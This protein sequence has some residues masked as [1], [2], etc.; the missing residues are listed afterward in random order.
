M[1]GEKPMTCDDA[2]RHLAVFLDGEL[3]GA[4]HDALEHHLEICRSCFSR[5]EFERRLK[6]EVG[7]LRRDDVPASF[8]DRIRHLL[9]SFVPTTARPSDNS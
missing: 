9:D 4:P 1:N 5:A 7:R 8:Q 3:H 2:V 6:A